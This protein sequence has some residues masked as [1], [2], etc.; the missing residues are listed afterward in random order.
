MTVL[1]V[2]TVAIPAGRPGSMCGDLDRVDLEQI[3]DR[4]GFWGMIR[5]VQLFRYPLLG[6]L[7]V[8]EPTTATVDHQ[9][10]VTRVLG[11]LMVAECITALM[12]FLGRPP[13]MSFDRAL[14]A[15]ARLG[16]AL[17]SPVAILASHHARL[18]AAHVVVGNGFRAIASTARCIL[19]AVAIVV[20]VVV[21]VAI[22]SAS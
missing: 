4:C 9:R 1:V 12:L 2:C 20:I 8:C 22:A 10:R 6:G 19:L 14:S 18:A 16:I 15:A 5:A 17:L 7:P 13:R 3:D 11:P 21:A